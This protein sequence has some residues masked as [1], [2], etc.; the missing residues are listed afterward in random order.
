[1]SR[2]TGRGPRCREPGRPAVRGARRAL[3]LTQQ[4]LAAAAGV[5]RQ[6]VAGIEAG[7]WDP[8]LPVA[9]AVA[10]ALGSTV[11]ALF[12]DTHPMEPVEATPLLGASTPV[13]RRVE[14]A[15]VGRRTVAM[16]LGAGHGLRAGFS[17]A[18]GVVTGHG[19]LGAPWQVEPVRPVRPGLVVAGCDP[20]LPLIADHLASSDPP[21]AMSWW[22]ATSRQALTWLTEGLVHLAGMHLEEGVP[23]EHLLAGVGSPPVVVIGFAEWDEG[24]ALRPGLGLAGVHEIAE[25]H[26]RVVNREPGSEARTMFQRHLLRTKVPERSIV[27]LESAVRGHMLVAASVA[28]GLGDV[29]VTTEP[30][31]LAHGLDFV[32]LVSEQSVLVARASTVDE[33]E[34]TAVLAALRSP[35]LRRQLGALDGY[36]SVGSCGVAIGSL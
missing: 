26:L 13:P 7:S 22:P 1:M 31:A 29:G 19:P 20:A 4:D 11:E 14:L 5:S 24:L 9:L 35:A 18:H 15:Q 36:R 30:S 16:P 21:T 6:A 10:R 33:P 2:T 12:A 34:I 23:L 32:P 28:A 17:A 25:R 27:G 3:G 8:S